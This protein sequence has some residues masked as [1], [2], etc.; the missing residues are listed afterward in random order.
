MGQY[1]QSLQGLADVFIRV[2]GSFER[3]VGRDVSHSCGAR[4]LGEELTEVIP[5]GTYTFHHGE[6]VEHVFVA[7]RYLA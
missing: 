2:H 4:T 5:S 3:L 1:V 7:G 6:N